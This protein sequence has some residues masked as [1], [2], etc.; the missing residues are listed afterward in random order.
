MTELNYRGNFLCDKLNIKNLDDLLKYSV[1]ELLRVP[2]CGRFTIK[3]TLL[4]LVERKLGKD[5]MRIL[6][7]VMME[8]VI[9]ENGDTY[10]KG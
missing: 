6:W 4:H 1:A 2:N 3:N 5:Y 10:W 7:T 9:A 8:K